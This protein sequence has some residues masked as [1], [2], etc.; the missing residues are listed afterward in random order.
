[1]GGNLSKSSGKW[2]GG[3]VSGSIRAPDVIFHTSKAPRA[4]CSPEIF[5]SRAVPPSKMQKYHENEQK[6]I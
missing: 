1:M 4:S 5:T 3:A 2:R 6:M